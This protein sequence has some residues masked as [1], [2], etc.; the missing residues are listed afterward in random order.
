VI[1]VRPVGDDRFE[2]HREYS[3]PPSVSRTTSGRPA[4]SFGLKMYSLIP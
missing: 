1:A 2:I 3:H 4:L